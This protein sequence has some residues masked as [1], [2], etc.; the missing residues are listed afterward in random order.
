METSGKN[1]FLPCKVYSL[2]L[3][4]EEAT[5]IGGKIPCCTSGGFAS[6]GE[7]TAAM[8]QFQVCELAWQPRGMAG[9]RQVK[10][11]KV[12][13]G[14]LYGGNTNNTVIILKTQQ[15][16]CEEKRVEQLREEKVALCK[17]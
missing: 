5:A 17:D 1:K 11:A 8:G 15:V 4:L 13:L 3:L 12:G 7:T 16:N 14:Q 2:G 10:G 9:P 6:F